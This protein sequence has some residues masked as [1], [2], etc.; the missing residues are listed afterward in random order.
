MAPIDW[1]KLHTVVKYLT[2]CVV[3]APDRMVRADLLELRLNYLMRHIPMSWNYDIDSVTPKGKWSFRVGFHKRPGH[4]YQ[5]L[6][7]MPVWGLESDEGF[8]EFWI[9]SPSGERRGVF[10]LEE[11]VKYL[12][13]L[14][15]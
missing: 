5:P 9:I 7:N 14:H 1:N 15:K 4:Y 12:T 3:N 8:S 2:E 13:E 10:D 6:D 11:V